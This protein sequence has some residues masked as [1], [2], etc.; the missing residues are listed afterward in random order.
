MNTLDIKIA[1]ADYFRIKKQRKLYKRMK[2]VGKNVYISPGYQISSIHNIEIGNNVWIGRNCMMG[3][4]GGLIIEDGTIISHNIEIWTQNHRYQDKN[5]ESIPYD[6]NFIKKAVHICENVWIGSKV[7]ILPG[8][9]IGEGSVIGAGAI[10]T[11]DV[12]PCAVVGGNPAK[13]VKYRDKK[14]YL[15]LKENNQIYLKM[16]YNYDISSKRIK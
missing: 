6:S 9:T 8:V 16:N 7:I 1:I 4:E 5:L 10:I 3:G 12:P 14:Q 11:K 15:K 13:V 2:S